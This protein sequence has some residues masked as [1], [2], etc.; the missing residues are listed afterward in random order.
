VC[1]LVE[2]T[3]GREVVSSGK[4]LA[5][6]AVGV[7][8]TCGWTRNC[9]GPGQVV[10]AEGQYG[11]CRCRSG[12]VRPALTVGKDVVDVRGGVRRG[13]CSDQLRKTGDGLQSC[14]WSESLRRHWC[15]HRRGVVS[16]GWSTHRCR[17]SGA[18]AQGGGVHRVGK[19]EPERPVMKL[20]TASG[21]LDVCKGPGRPA[22]AWGC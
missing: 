2:E 17:K 13:V 10:G 11:A 20:P 22:G 16:C 8:T 5:R 1:F 4:R 14:R 21:P 9:P 18:S 15:Q 7:P 6:H 3:T 19:G 12:G